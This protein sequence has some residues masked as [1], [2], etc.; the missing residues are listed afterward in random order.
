[1]VIVE[2]DVLRE[3][4]RI[5]EGSAVIIGVLS[6]GLGLRVCDLPFP[7]VAAAAANLT[8]TRDPF[9]RLIV[10]QAVVAKAPLI[11]RDRTILDNS[12]VAYWGD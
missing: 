8:W 3:I 2:I 12:A 7:A 11:T 4:G 6:R 10:A 9:D 5:D 1:M